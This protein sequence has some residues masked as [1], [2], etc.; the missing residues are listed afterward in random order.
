[1]LPRQSATSAVPSDQPTIAA[2]IAAAGDGD[3]ICVGDGTYAETVT[4]AGAGRSLTLRA[5]GQKAIWNGQLLVQ[6]GPGAGHTLSVE[7]FTFGCA[8]TNVSLAGAEGRISVRDNHFENPCGYALDLENTGAGSVTVIFEQNQLTDT[9]LTANL[10]APASGA[11]G[12]VALKNNLVTGGAGFGLLGDAAWAR[13]VVVGNTFDIDPGYTLLQLDLGA[14]EGAGSSVRDNILAGGDTA[15]S[16]LSCKKLEVAWNLLFSA[17][18]TYGNVQLG[19]GNLETD[20]LFRAADDRRPQP[21][22]PALYAGRRTP[23][24]PADEDLPDDIEARPRPALDID[25]GAYQHE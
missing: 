17:D 5:G 6:G 13:Y 21:W 4:L 24:A 14:D 20:P 10:A 3:V 12:L 16:C 15:V 22:S 18:A 11:K 8:S 25:M 19:E 1:M 23:G 2:A 7:G 9:S